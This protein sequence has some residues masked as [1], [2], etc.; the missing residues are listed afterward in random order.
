MDRPAL[1]PHRPTGP[2]GKSQ[3]PQ[4]GVC[5]SH[6]SRQVTWVAPTCQRLLSACRRPVGAYPRMGAYIATKGVAIPLRGTPPAESGCQWRGKDPSPVPLRLV[7]TPAAGHPL[8]KGEG[9]LF[10]FDHPWPLLN[11]GGE[12]RVI[13]P[14]EQSAREFGSAPCRKARQR[15]GASG[16][17][18]GWRDEQSSRSGRAECGKCRVSRR[19]ACR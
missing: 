6:D 3:T 9:W 10:S 1:L 16:C 18:W 12:S 17:G 7:K 5:A 15:P 11:Q 14:Q 13:P 4:N 19:R 2:F 8:P